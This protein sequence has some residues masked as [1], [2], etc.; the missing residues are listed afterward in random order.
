MPYWTDAV[1]QIPFAVDTYRDKQSITKTVQVGIEW[2]DGT[3]AGDADYSN[4]YDN[5]FVLRGAIYASKNSHIKQNILG[6]H[7]LLL[8]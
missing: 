2:G 4:E 8:L 5:Y 3:W 1:G 7:T 6:K